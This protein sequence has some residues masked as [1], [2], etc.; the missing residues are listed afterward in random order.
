[1]GYKLQWRISNIKTTHFLLFTNVLP[2]QNSEY[3]SD[4]ICAPPENTVMI[5]LTGHDYITFIP[6]MDREPKYGVQIVTENKQHKNYTLLFA[7]VLLQ[8]V[9]S[10]GLK[11]HRLDRKKMEK[12][13]ERWA[14]A[15]QEV[16]E[17][18][19][20][21]SFYIIF[22]CIFLCSHLTI[23][24]QWPLWSNYQTN[25]K[26]RPVNIMVTINVITCYE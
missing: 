16:I 5:N 11:E 22:I 23:M 26:W 10:N 18:L 17:D 9:A 14:Q 20:V 2:K 12:A 15:W 13:R 19:A 21:H 25:Q 3:L 24:L 1:M 7:N 4:F 8:V 6:L